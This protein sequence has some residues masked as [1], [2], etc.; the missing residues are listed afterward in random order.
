[1]V[2][3]AG[4]FVGSAICARLAAGKVPVLALTRNELD[5]LKPEAAATLQRL[6]RADDG[7]VFVS[8]LAPTRNNAMLID[9]LR[10]AGAVSAAL[11][12]Q[13]RCGLFGRCQ[14]GGRALMPAAVKPAGQCISDAR[15]CCAQRSSCRSRSCGRP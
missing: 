14:S 4:G 3:G 13:L 2:I 6:L 8:A 1:M 5:L 10:M 11:A 9:S 15:L 12:A 7:V